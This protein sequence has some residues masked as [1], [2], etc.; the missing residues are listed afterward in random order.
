M[1]KLTISRMLRSCL[2]FAGCLF[3]VAGLSGP[4]LRTEPMRWGYTLEGSPVPTKVL[5]YIDP[6]FSGILLQWESPSPNGISPVSRR[7]AFFSW[8]DISYRAPNGSMRRV[9]VLIIYKVNVLLCM[10]GIALSL[11]PATRLLR[12]LRSRGKKAGVRS[13]RDESPENESKG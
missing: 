1:R 12:D 8:Q 4:V 2:L 13:A 6:W 11:W 7:T 3:F 5:I 10:G 9:R